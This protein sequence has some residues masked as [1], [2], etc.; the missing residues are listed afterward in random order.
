M[1]SVNL[2]R[3]WRKNGQ[4]GSEIIEFAL[5]AFFMVPTLLF[6]FVNSMNLIRMI[7]AT[8]VTRDIGDLYIHGVDYTT[9]E[10]QS[11][12]QKLAGG[13]N[14]QIGSSFTGNNAVNHGNGGTGYIIVAEIMYIGS[15]SCSALPSN[16]SC[17]NQN[18]YVFLQY[19]DFG[20]KTVQINGVQVASA[21]GTTSAA[22]NANGMVQNYMT[23]P[24]AVATTAAGFFQTQLTDGQVAYVAETF[25]ASPDLNFTAYPAGGIHTLD[26]F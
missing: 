17:T 23:D 16:V 24:N 14:L 4:S 21:L 19:I 15:G 20:N 18:K 22:E 7:E 11:V 12:A 10:A 6:M 3:S 9:Y 5:Y 1:R 13:F 25:F 2:A 26:F 8:Q